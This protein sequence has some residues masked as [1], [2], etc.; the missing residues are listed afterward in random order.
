MSTRSGEE[1][2]EK[3]DSKEPFF[4]GGTTE[5][6]SVSCGS[7]ADSGCGGRDLYSSPRRPEFMHR[8]DFM[9]A[10]VCA[11]ARVKRS[12]LQDD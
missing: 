8:Y 2:G 4:W 6:A 12:I 1:D 9:K 7:V 11:C 3:L 10:H 5:E